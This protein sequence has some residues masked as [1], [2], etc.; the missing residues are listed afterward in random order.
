MAWAANRWTMTCNDERRAREEFLDRVQAALDA[1]ARLDDLRA[2]LGDE[3]SGL[4]FV[5][6]FREP[7]RRAT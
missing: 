3:A 2:A 6:E 5:T 4:L 1:G 7:V